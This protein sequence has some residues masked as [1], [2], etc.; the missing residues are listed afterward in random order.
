MDNT[1]MR[2]VAE[3]QFLA[4]CFHTPGPQAQAL[5]YTVVRAGHLRAA[6]DYRIERR[7]CPGQDILFCLRGAGFIRRGPE[8]FRVGPG[9]LAW[10][11]GRY[12]HAHR[13]DTLDP[14]E[15]L[16][17]RFDSHDLPPLCAMLSIEKAPVFR[18]VD[19]RKVSAIFHRIFE[20]LE[21]R[22]LAMDA[23]LHAEIAA[24]LAQL[25]RARHHHPPEAAES[26]QTLSPQ[27]ERAFTQMKLYSHRLWQ[28]EDLAQLAG[29]SAPHFFRCFK[30]VTGS[31]PIDWLRR[32]RINQAKRLLTQS[33]DPIGDIAERV[34]YSDPFYFSRDFKRMTGHSPTEY[35]HH[36]Q[37]HESRN[38]QH[39]GGQAE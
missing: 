6:P 33:I 27:L 39:R 2:P 12:P 10:I 38:K 7:F 16:W 29:M 4:S 26:P 9:E 17:L 13:P 34:G 3:T 18:G 1:I 22:P 35:R 19:R 37:G 31:S 8:E 23:L 32:E 5:F 20:L 21:H 15:L 25:F 36:E 30:R 28:V 24:L 11:D 14:W